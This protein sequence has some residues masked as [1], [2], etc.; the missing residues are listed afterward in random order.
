M[1]NPF[2][3]LFEGEDLVP[4]PLLVP[5]GSGRKTMFEFAFHRIS[6]LGESSSLLDSLERKTAPSIATAGKE[7]F[8]VKL[9]C[10]INTVM[11]ES[12][13]AKS[14][15]DSPSLV[16]VPQLWFA[17]DREELW[18]HDEGTYY[19]GNDHESVVPLEA[20]RAFRHIDR[21]VLWIRMKP[22]TTS[23]RCYRLSL[24]T[25]SHH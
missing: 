24:G 13:D 23:A 11:W 4:E 17:V 9:L 25:F 12:K 6:G 20:A 14:M 7:L 10:D 19:F 2:L 16:T 21:E 18:I 15:K 5:K 8:L 3:R 1:G 22:P